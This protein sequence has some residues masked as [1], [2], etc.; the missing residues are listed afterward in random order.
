MF[1]MEHCL[2][3]HG[4]KTWSSSLAHMISDK[5]ACLIQK[6]SES[7]LSWS[8]CAVICDTANAAAGAKVRKGAVPMHIRFGRCYSS[9]PLEPARHIQPRG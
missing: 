1:P 6:W 7:S 4:R 9:S 3:Q 8:K 2:I 5:Y